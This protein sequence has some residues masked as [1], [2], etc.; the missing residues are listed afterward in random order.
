M[1]TA[2]CTGPKVSRYLIQLLTLITHLYLSARWLDAD[3]RMD[4]KKASC[5][6]EIGFRAQNPLIIL[7]SILYLKGGEPMWPS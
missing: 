4:T 5:F 7:G 2:D 3:L 1:N 6:E